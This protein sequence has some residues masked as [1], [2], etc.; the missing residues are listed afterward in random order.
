MEDLMDFGLNRPEH[1]VDLMKGLT[2][3]EAAQAEKA[4]GVTLEHLAEIGVLPAEEEEE[5]VE[6]EDEEEEE[7]EEEEEKEAPKPKPKPAAAKPRQPA[8]IA[9]AA[10]SRA[11]A[12]ERMRIHGYTPPPRK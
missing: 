2:R 8:V 7:E 1:Y 3:N 5:E 10:A 11:R 4:L 9:A 6:P 12:Q